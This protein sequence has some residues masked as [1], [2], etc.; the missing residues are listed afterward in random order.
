MKRFILLLMLTLYVAVANASEIDSYK[1]KWSDLDT[2]R[3][4]M[5]TALVVADMKQTLNIRKINSGPTPLVYETNPILGKH[6]T[7][8]KVVLYFTGV[9]LAHYY[10]SKNLEAGW[11]REA[12][13]YGWIVVESAVVLR[14]KKIQIQYKF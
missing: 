8:T 2:A 5:F 1:Y 11:K 4:S 12:W 13:Q 14:N 6:P 7:D 3:Q 9:A 10:I